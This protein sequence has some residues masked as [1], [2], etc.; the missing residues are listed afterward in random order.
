MNV[1]QM[2]EAAREGA[3]LEFVYNGLLGASHATARQYAEAIRAVGPASCIL[4]SD[5]GQVGNPLHPD[6]LAAFLAAVARG[7]CFSQA[8]IDRMSKTNPPARLGLGDRLG[9]TKP[10]W[11]Q[12]LWPLAD[13]EGLGPASKPSR[14]A[15]AWAGREAS[16]LAS[17]LTLLA[18]LCA[19]PALSQQPPEIPFESVANWLEFPDG[20]NFGEAAGV[21]LNSKG[22][23]FV[24]TRAHARSFS[25]SIRTGR[26]CARS[27]RIFTDLC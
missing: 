19:A 12:I 6:G 1:A 13:G 14:A 7:R 17:R 18:A 26:C 25:D 5:L 4:A 8:D 11:R 9:Y 16:P 15:G 24:Y 2:R 20:F 22:H 3:Y 10:R 21:A 27:A 23:I